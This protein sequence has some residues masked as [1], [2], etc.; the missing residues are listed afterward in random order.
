MPVYP[1]RNCGKFVTV[2][3]PPK[4]IRFSEAP[5]PKTETVTV[6]CPH[7]GTV[8]SYEVPTK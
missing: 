7:C 8:T 1:C 3:D 4:V 2:N 6:R 5:P